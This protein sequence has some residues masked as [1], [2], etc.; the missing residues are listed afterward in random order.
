MTK[1]NIKSFWATVENST[2]IEQSLDTYSKE[3]AWP[4]ETLLML[5]NLFFCYMS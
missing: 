5:F 3:L 4:P 1:C 2:V